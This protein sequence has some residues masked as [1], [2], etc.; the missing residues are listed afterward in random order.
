MGGGHAERDAGGLDLVLRPDQALRHRLLR[1]QEGARDLL[2]GQAAERPQ[3]QRDLAV[4]GERRMAAGEEQLEP[5]V[6]N[7]GLIHLVLRGLRHI[8]QARLL[9]EGAVSPDPVDGPVARGRHQPGPRVVRCPVAR[10]ALRRDRERLLSGLL[11]ELE[12]AEE[13]DQVGEDAAPLVAED[14]LEDR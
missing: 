1:D 13:A 3:R 2:S 6:G 9:G 8:E 12:A 11:G 5:L 14:L 10:P 7:G 4:E